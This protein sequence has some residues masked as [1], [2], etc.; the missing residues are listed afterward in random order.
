MTKMTPL[1]K[2][3]KKWYSHKHTHQAVSDS[4]GKSPGIMVASGEV[5]RPVANVTPLSSL[6]CFVVKVENRNH[7]FKE[8]KRTKRRIKRL[9]KLVNFFSHIFHNATSTNKKI[10][11]YKETRDK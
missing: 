3:K 4:F 10:S 2:M 5:K 6:S 7:F 8:R 9:A 11:K 1:R